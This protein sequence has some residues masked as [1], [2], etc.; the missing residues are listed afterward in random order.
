MGDRKVQN[1]ALVQVRGEG[2]VGRL[3]PQAHFAADEFQIPVAEESTRKKAGFDQDLKPVT[4]AEDDAA[5]GSEPAN[6]AHNGRKA[7]NRAA[8]EVIAIG[9]SPWEQY[10]VDL[11]QIGGFMP[12]KFR[13]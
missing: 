9:E 13:L 6:R 2:R 8:A 12:D 11:A 3:G 7:R 5:V 1:L 4:D 10:C